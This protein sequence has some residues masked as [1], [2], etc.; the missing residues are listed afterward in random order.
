MGE[1]E[2][3]TIYNSQFKNI[4]KKLLAPWQINKHTHSDEKKKRGNGIWQGFGCVSVFFVCFLPSVSNGFWYNNKTK[5]QYVNEVL[6][7]LYF[8][9]THKQ[10]CFLFCLF[11]DPARC[12]RLNS[13]SGYHRLLGAP[14]RPVLMGFLPVAPLLPAASVHLLLQDASLRHSF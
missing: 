5:H 10:M 12:L 13:T 9:H 6:A 11:N 4:K 8:E 7:S 2:E 1:N 3:I 14:A